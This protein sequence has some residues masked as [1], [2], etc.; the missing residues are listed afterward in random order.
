MNKAKDKNNYQC[1]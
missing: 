1:G